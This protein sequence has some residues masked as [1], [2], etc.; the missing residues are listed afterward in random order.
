MKIKHLFSLSLFLKKMNKL[1]VKLNKRIKSILHRISI[2][3]KSSLFLNN[4][5]L[6]Y[7]FICKFSDFKTR[8]KLNN[9]EV[10]KGSFQYSC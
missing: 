3:G 4:G 10:L 1:Y 9:L 7:R 6:K 8:Y 5:V 2:M